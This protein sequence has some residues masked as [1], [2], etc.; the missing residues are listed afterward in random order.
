MK[1]LHTGHRIIYVLFGQREFVFRTLS[2]KEYRDIVNIASSEFELEDIICQTALLSPEDY[3][4]SI[5]PLAGLSNNIAPSIIE[6]SGF[7]SMDV[8]LDIYDKSKEKIKLFDQQCM[9]IVK[10]CFPEFRYEEIEDWTWE[11][12]I[13]MATKA[14]YMLQIQGHK[15]QLV[16][17]SEEVEEAVQKQLAPTTEERDQLV[18]ELRENGIDPMYYFKD[19][20]KHDKDYMETP[21]I[22]GIHWNDEGVLYEIRK[23]MERP[24]KR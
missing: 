22:G 8:I 19:S 3:D 16:N 1:E 13:D 10:V 17:K 2:R 24:S 4:F 18:K 15:I 9:S 20:L 5:S 14:E 12:L 7:T 11:R 23:Q 21:L 6:N